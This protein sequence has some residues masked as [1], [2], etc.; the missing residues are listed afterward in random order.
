MRLIVLVLTTALLAACGEQ[1]PAPGPSATASADTEDV[2]PEASPRD[3][4]ATLVVEDCI[5]QFSAG[6]EMWGE[7][8]VLAGFAYD[9]GGLDD[10][11]MDA[12]IASLRDREGTS[13]L[14]FNTGPNAQIAAEEF[15]ASEQVMDVEFFRGGEIKILRV[16]RTEAA[17]FATALREGCEGAPQGATVRQVTF[18]QQAVEDS[19]EDE[20]E[21]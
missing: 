7:T 2:A 14:I 13:H 15:L 12:L 19:S 8:P 21:N 4:E 10:T 6:R 3:A 11:Q 9:L 18:S 17:P 5:A 16:R 20:T 1:S